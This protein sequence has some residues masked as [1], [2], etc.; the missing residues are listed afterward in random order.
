MPTFSTFMKLVR[1]VIIALFAFLFLL[2]FYSCKKE[3][4][5]NNGGE[6]RFSTDTLTF[7]T[8]FT[9]YASFTLAVKIFNPQNQKIIVSN[10]RLEK[11]QS[12]FFNLNVDGVAGNNVNNTEVAANDSFYVFATVKIDPTNENNPFLIE[13]RLIA[14]LNGKEFSIPVLAYGQ[15]AHY[16]KQE[17]MTTNT[18]WVNDKPYVILQSAGVDS[19]VTLTI[20]PGCRIYMNQ[21]SRLFV[22]GNVI[23]NGTKQDSI[24]FQGNRL[25]RAYFGYEGYPGEWGGLY[26]FPSSNNNFLKWVVI[27]NCGNTAFGT[28]PAAIQ[29]TGEPSLTTQ[30]TMENTVIENSIGYGVLSFTGNIKAQN[31]LVHTTGAQA[32][33]IF[34]GGNYS[35][36]NCDFLNFGSDKVKHI[37]ESN[38]TV[39]VLNYFDISQSQRIVSDVNANFTNCLIYGSLEDELFCNKADEAAYNANFTNCIIKAKEP[40]PGYVTVTDCKLNENPLFNDLAKWDYRLQEGSPAIDAGTNVFPISND[41]DD[42]PLVTPFDIGCYQR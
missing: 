3:T 27:R 4:L 8:V 11:G 24:I 30:L 14:T 6:L 19:N 33:A 13:D 18:T 31:C 35:F 39:A 40:I 10:V 25:D 38:P 16:I 9:E 20:D 41:L 32:L 22:W 12:S 17:D 1:V 7:D 21:D 2:S 37:D 36:D 15:N 42:K 34:Q 23:A 5:L 26:F 28:L 29:V